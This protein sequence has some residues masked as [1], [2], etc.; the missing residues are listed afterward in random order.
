MLQIAD[1]RANLRSGLSEFLSAGAVFR[2]LETQAALDA[3]LL[4]LNS[5]VM[6]L[7]APAKINLH[8]RIGTRR[9]DGFHPLVSWMCTIGLFDN[10]TLEPVHVDARAGSQYVTLACDAPGLAVDQTNLVVRTA[11]GFLEAARRTNEVPA[12]AGFHAT[13][14]KRIPMGA[15]LGG[16]SSDG[17]R[18]LVGLNAHC[19]TEWSVDTLSAFAARFG[20]DMP[21]FIHGPSSICRGRGEHVRP[22]TPPAAKSAVLLLP[23]IMMPTPL[24]YRRF[25]EMGL[26]YDREV[27]ADLNWSAWVRL[28]AQNLLA[29]LVNDLE[30]PAFAIAP[31]LAE[32]RHRAEL[33]L[34]RPVRMSGSG[35]SLFTLFDEHEEAESAAQKLG[36]QFAVR[37]LAVQLAPELFDDLHPVRLS[38]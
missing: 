31:E 24:V 26:G 38:H 23:E 5:L 6:K 8:L 22:I 29:N 1:Q 12:T 37:A 3:V 32:L 17:A 16:G 28:G 9:N 7:L 14:A 2:Q 30:A 15:G 18:T 33:L 20:S 13:L 19:R 35:S 11:S 34:K 27:E 10:L 21:F 25:D 4:P 36:E